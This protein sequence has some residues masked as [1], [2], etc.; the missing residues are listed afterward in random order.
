MHQLPVF[1]LLHSSSFVQLLCQPV[2]RIAGRLWAIC[3]V[4]ALAFVF[5]STVRAHTL[6]GLLPRAANNPGKHV[7]VDILADLGL[8]RLVVGVLGHNDL[9]AVD[10][11]ATRLDD[12]LLD[13]ILALQAK[14]ALE[15]RHGLHIPER[16]G[17][18][19]GDL[20]ADGVLKALDVGGQVGV[21]VVGVEGA[22]E[23]VKGGAFEMCVEGAK[24][25]DGLGELG[26]AGEG[27]GG[28]EVEGEVE[29]Q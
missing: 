22:P 17:D 10:L 23:A 18:Y 24:L 25:D 29:L 16:L 19:L 4:D 27:G 11:P 26:A 28:E 9:V 6:C 13:G 14:P 2:H 20:D 7:D 12:V 3:V 8:L 5:L 21:E 1:W 15:H